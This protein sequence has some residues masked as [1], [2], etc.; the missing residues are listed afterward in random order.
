M[1]L[2]KFKN[3]P[4]RPL[5]E[6]PRIKVVERGSIEGKVATLSLTLSHQGREDCW[7]V[8]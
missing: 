4:P 8:L 6:R 5:R 3:L 7:W 1:I 2:R